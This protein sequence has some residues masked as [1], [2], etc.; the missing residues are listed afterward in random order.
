MKKKEK[1]EKKE[2]RKD[3]RRLD[4]HLWYNNQ[5]EYKFWI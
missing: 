1:K 3:K 2:E 4:R 5:K